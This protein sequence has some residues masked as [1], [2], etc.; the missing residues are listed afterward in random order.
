MSGLLLRWRVPDPPVALRWRGPQSML[1]AIARSPLPELA[2]F[3][4]I[5]PT[6]TIQGPGLTLAGRVFSL[7]YDAIG[8]ELGLPALAA[9]LDAIPEYTASGDGLKLELGQFSLDYGEIGEGLGLPAFAAAIDAAFDAIPEYTASGNGIE[10]TAAQFSL[11]YGEIDTGLGLTANFAPKANPVFTGIVTAP[12]IV[13]PTLTLGD[14]GVANRIYLDGTK[15]SIVGNSLSGSQAHSALAVSQTWNTTG[16]PTAIQLDVTDTASD[17]NSLLMDLRTAG[18]SRFRVRKNGAFGIPQ[19]EILPSSSLFGQFLFSGIERVRIG[20]SFVEL[21]NGGQIRW[22]N[23]G[24][25]GSPDL[26]L[27][28]DAA[29]TLALRSAANPQGFN[30]YNTFTDASNYE[31]GYA[32]FAGNSFIIGT[33]AAGTGTGRDVQFARAGLEFFRLNSNF[34]VT[35]QTNRRLRLSGGSWIDILEAGL[36]VAAPP[37]NTVRIYAEDNGTGKTRLMARF[38]T[39]AAQ[40]ITIEP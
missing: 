32:R 28:R 13:A 18:T 38:A 8:D 5:A 24:S 4:P 20:S 15:T 2:G 25:P 16:A 37:A 36:A 9:A 33:E 1:E 10:L 40:Q 7:D 26:Y 6:Y 17:T 29:N 23:A 12:Q 34:E 39:G 35:L 21:N 11:N 14:A 22:S 27:T 3:L 31:R 30:I 19:F